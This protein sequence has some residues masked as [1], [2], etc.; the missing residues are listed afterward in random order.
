MS[1][2]LSVGQ[3]ARALEEKVGETIRPTRISSLLYN[4]ELNEKY[5]PRIGHAHLI[6][7]D[8]LPELERIMRRRGWI[9]RE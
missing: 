6:Q 2:H 4:R 1:E 9:G 7:A 5:C 3:A 8:Y